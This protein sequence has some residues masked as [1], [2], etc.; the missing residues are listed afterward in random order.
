MTP[1]LNHKLKKYGIRGVKFCPFEDVLGIGH[2]E[3]FT[4]ILVPGK[5]LNVSSMGANKA[6]VWLAV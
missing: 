4:S 2:L 6:S 3:G 5:K 1:Y